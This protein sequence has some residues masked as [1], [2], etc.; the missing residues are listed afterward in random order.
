M[1]SKAN[2]QIISLILFSA[3]LAI[4]Q[5]LFKKAAFAGLNGGLSESIGSTW[6]IL[7]VTFYAGASVLWVWILRTTPL[8]MAY[9]FAALGFVLVPLAAAYFFGEELSWRYA[10]GSL[11]I[12]S[13]IVVVST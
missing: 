3:L 10:F 8:S 6:M 4:G 9:P 11:L 1:R 5:I 7:A 2:M 13:G 12:I